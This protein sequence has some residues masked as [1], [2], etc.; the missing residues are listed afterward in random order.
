[1]T[2]RLTHKELEFALSIVEPELCCCTDLYHKVCSSAIDYNRT[3]KSLWMLCIRLHILVHG[4]VPLDMKGNTDWFKISKVMIDFVESKG[5]DVHTKITEA[6]KDFAS[7]PRKRNKKAAL[8]LMSKFYKK[9]KSWLPDNIC[10]HRETIIKEL[11]LGND[12]ET[13]FFNVLT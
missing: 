6:K 12:V 9:N 13:V 5:Y 2:E 11:M 8:T 1:M 4:R 3:D 7:R 10:E